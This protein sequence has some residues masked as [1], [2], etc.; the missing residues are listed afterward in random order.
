MEN[1]VNEDEHPFANDETSDYETLPKSMYDY[2]DEGQDMSDEQCH[3]ELLQHFSMSGKQTYIISYLMLTIIS[4]LAKT[5]TN[6]MS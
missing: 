2:D 3:G 1:N 6:F 4:D 5:Q